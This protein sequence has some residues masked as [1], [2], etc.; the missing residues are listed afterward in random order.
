MD[1]VTRTEL[2][3]RY[4]RG[5][6]E[7]MNAVGDISP[8][9]LDARGGPSEWS[10]R[11]VVHHLADSEMTGAIRLRRLIA[12]E[13]PQ[14]VG[15]DEEGFAQRLHYDRPI[16]SSLAAFGAARASTADILDRISETDWARSGSHNETGTFGVE[17]WLETYAPHADEHAEQIRRARN[18]GP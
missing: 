10:A 17:T 11:Q 8:E 2:I 7:V 5:Y 18:S 4:R 9:E 6:D 15:Y 12:E 3:D 1:P 14:I 13:D 16:D